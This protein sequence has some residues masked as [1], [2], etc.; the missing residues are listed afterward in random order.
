VSTCDQTAGFAPRLTSTNALLVRTRPSPPP[1]ASQ[2]R[3]LA[4]AEGVFV[5]PAYT[6]KGFAGMLDHIRTARVK[7]GSTHSL[8]AHR[9]RRNLFEIPEVVGNVACA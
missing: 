9:R 3:E 8:S 1:K 5:G 4:Q 6:G 7:P 2:I